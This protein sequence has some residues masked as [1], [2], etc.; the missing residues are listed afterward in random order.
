MHETES[1]ERVKQ[2]RLERGAEHNNKNIY[3]QNEY[4]KVNTQHVILSYILYMIIM[5]YTFNIILIVSHSIWTCNINS[6]QYQ[7][8][9]SNNDNNN[10][11][12]NITI[13]IAIIIMVI[14][15]S[16]I[17]ISILIIG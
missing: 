2:E 10:N 11:Q 15:I 17:T 5:K 6:N 1:F 3:S 8:Y 4:S 13:L 16:E 12:N 9:N 7:Y 14:I